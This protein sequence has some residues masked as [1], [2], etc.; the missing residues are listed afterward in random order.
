MN[1]SQIVARIVRI[2]EDSDAAYDAKPKEQQGSDEAAERDLATHDAIVELLQD[3]G[4]LTT[5]ESGLWISP[6]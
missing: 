1:D 2:I 5:T 4:K 3:E 6:K